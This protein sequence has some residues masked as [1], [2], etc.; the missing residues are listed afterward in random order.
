M[1]SRGR[2]PLP[3]YDIRSPSRSA[4]R[5]TVEALLLHQDVELNIGMIALSPA[6]ILTGTAR[7][8][9]GA[10]ALRLSEAQKL[11]AN[12]RLVMRHEA[13]ANL[14]MYA[15]IVVERLTKNVNE[16]HL[17]EIFGQFGHI[18]DLDLP[19]SRISGTNRGTAYILY[20]EELDA[21]A[22]I[23]HMHE[24]Q[25]D[26]ATINV[27]IVLPRQKFSP[28]PP[29]A[30]RRGGGFNNRN[31]P[32]AAP[33]GG[34][35]LCLEAVPDPPMMATA[36][37]AVGLPT[38]AGRDHSLRLSGT[39]KAGGTDG[40]DKEEAALA[41]GAEMGVAVPASGT[42]VQALEVI[43][44]ALMAEG[45]MKTRPHGVVAEMA[46]DSGIGQYHAA[47]AGAD[48]GKCNMAEKERVVFSIG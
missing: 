3:Q 17:Y 10:E 12:A 26:G 25:L 37:T 41:D 13:A 43:M 47:G 11:A 27:S 30:A 5:D 15:Q 24:A 19:I 6:G 33:R 44:A 32:N 23:A 40:K 48:V 34:R 22:A 16:D 9:A 28:P 4:S 46:T 2:S 35:R 45:A 7:S 21:E 14:D 8:A 18:R 42:L 31:A 1:T 36:D 20:V 39:V 38:L 29:L